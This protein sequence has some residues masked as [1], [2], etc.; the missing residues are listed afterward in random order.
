MGYIQIYF[1][2]GDNLIT[3]FL[4]WVFRTSADGENWDTRF[5]IAVNNNS[6][7]MRKIKVILKNTLCGKII[8]IMPKR[9]LKIFFKQVGFKESFL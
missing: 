7:F 8:K 6:C 2:P 5:N 1:A 3:P 4:L 9:I